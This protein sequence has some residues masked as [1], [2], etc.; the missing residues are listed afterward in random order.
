MNAVRKIFRD[1]EKTVFVIALC[2]GACLNSAYAQEEGSGAGR[3]GGNLIFVG[4]DVTA[5]DAYPYFGY[6]HHFNN[7][8]AG[9]GLLIRVSG[10]YALYSYNSSA[11]P[12]GKVDGKAA[13]FDGMVGYQKSLPIVTVRGFLGP[14]FEN[15]D[16]SPN[17]RLDRNRGADAGIK[18]QGELETNYDSPYFASL[19]GSF[20]SAKHRYWTRLRGGYDFGNFIVGPEGGFFG[21]QEFDEQ[22]AGAF[23]TVKNLGP[24]WISAGVG[25]SAKSRNR[26]GD[27]AYGSLELSVAF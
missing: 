18:V 16:L 7:S 20:G 13:Q 24:T 14:E 12:G 6:I 21:N 10:F 19:I 4:G 3:P 23:V 15:D 8:L 2:L 9:D 11:V 1:A 5:K 25:F 27:G 17:N 22:R 26:G